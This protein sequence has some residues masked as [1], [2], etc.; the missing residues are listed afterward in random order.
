[1]PRPNKFDSFPSSHQQVDYVDV[2]KGTWATEGG[3][4]LINSHCRAFRNRSPGKGL[5]S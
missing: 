4:A 3:G 2:C 5:M 1:V